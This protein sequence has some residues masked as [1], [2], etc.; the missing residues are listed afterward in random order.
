MN[1]IS[2]LGKNNFSHFA[3]SISAPFN[4]GRYSNS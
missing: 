3:V 2:Q 4:F 1:T